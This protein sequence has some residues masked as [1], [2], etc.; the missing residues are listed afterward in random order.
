[1][2]DVIALLSR[3]PRHFW[4]PKRVNSHGLYRLGKWQLRSAKVLQTVLLVTPALLPEQEQ[5]QEQEQEQDKEHV[6]EQEPEE[7]ALLW[8]Y[9]YTNLFAQVHHLQL[10][11]CDLTQRLKPLPRTARGTRQTSSHAHAQVLQ[12][13]HGTCLCTQSPKPMPTT[14]WKQSPQNAH[15][16]ITT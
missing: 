10:R 13:R 6:Q 9:F 1:M 7:D 5:Q 14:R 2:I 4:V 11:T 8:N 12:L 15:V 16:D 3:K